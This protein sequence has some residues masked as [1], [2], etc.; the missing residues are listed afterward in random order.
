[1]HGDIFINVNNSLGMKP[2]FGHIK[3]LENATAT[4]LI[5]KK[6]EINV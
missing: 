3:K 6:E 1:V 4:D 2:S 5:I